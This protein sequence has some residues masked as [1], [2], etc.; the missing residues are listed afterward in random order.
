MDGSVRS[1]Y[2][3]VFWYDGHRRRIRSAST[4]TAELD[5]AK[6]WLDAFYLER[7]TG[8]AVCYACGQLKRQVAGHLVTA[9]IADYLEGTVPGKPSED[10]IRAR[11]DHVLAFIK[12]GDIDVT[13]DQIDELWVARFRAWSAKQPVVS[14]AG[15]VLRNR[16]LA[17]TEASVA[18]LSAAINDANRRKNT[19]HGASFRAH[20]LRTLNNTPEHR[21][22]VA[23]LAKMFRYAIAA[24]VRDEEE[25]ERRV[26]ERAA[27]HRFLLISVATWARPD[28]AHDFSV[29]PERVQWSSKAKVISLNP[30]GR[31]QTKKF[32]ATIP[33]PRQLALHPDAADKKKAFYV[34]PK[35]VR[36]PGRAWPRKLGCRVRARPD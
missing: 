9:A 1:P 4:R 24:D 30:R 26:R 13:C 32:R 29:K 31:R 5:A 23:E 7:S 19:P 35:S 27:L 17:T 34:G 2:F 6:T 22:D 14:T 21:S 28:A 15:K 36:R 16:S 10:V 25:R 8:K 12:H 3:A 11:L 33:C 18:Q 20:D